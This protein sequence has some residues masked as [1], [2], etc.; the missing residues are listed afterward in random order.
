MSWDRRRRTIGMLIA[1]PPD[2]HLFEIVTRRHELRSTLMTSNRPLEDW[3]KLIGDPP[4]ATA[5]LDRFMHYAEVALHLALEGDKR[6][7]VSVPTGRCGPCCDSHLIA[8]SRRIISAKLDGTKNSA[9][10]VAPLTPPATAV[11]NG[12]QKPPPLKMSGMKPT[13]VVMVVESTCRVAR[14]TTSRMAS[15]SPW[16]ASGSSRKAA[17]TT[18]ESLIATPMSPIAGKH[19]E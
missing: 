1:L 15:G 14:T 8:H 4:S 16:L 6:I 5:I 2:R 9:R 18:M 17:S 3:G 13:T 19:Q 7:T 12:G 10:S 11:A